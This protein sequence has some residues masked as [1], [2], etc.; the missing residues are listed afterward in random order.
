MYTTLCHSGIISCG[1]ML[2]TGLHVS[3]MSVTAEMNGHSDCYGQRQFDAY[4][5]CHL[6][7]GDTCDSDGMFT[8]DEDLGYTC[9][10]GICQG[11]YT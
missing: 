1:L 11:K 5:S 7:P 8:C 6:F 9:I 3:V 4:G 2:F 10:E